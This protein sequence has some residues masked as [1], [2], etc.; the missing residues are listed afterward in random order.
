MNRDLRYFSEAC[1]TVIR[2]IPIVSRNFPKITEDCF[3][4]AE[5]FQGRSENVVTMHMPSSFDI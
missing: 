3:K 5:D 4:T 2:T 1:P